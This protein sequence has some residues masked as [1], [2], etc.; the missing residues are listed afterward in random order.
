MFKNSHVLACL[1][2]GFISLA[3]LVIWGI[4]SV[5]ENELHSVGG[6]NQSVS[7]INPGQ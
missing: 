5:E 7:D 1:C 3:V 6:L 4:V 2:V